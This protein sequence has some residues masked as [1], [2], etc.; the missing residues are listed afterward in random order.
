MRVM[1]IDAS[2][3][4]T[5]YAIF[6]G[7]Q[8]VEYGAIPVDDITKPWRE[9]IVYMM[10]SLSSLITEKNIIQIIIETPVKTL[11][12]VNTL[13]QLFSLHG[14]LIG[15][16]ASHH[17]KVVPVEVSEW[18]QELGLSKGIKK[19]DN[20]KAILKQ[21]SIELANQLYGLDLKWKSAGSKFND[22]DIS[23]AI[24]IGHAVLYKNE[25][26]I[27]NQIKVGE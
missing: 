20:K 7:K 11:Q 23:D 2:T 18:R 12:N 26:M 1:S 3:R 10:Q 9:R 5:G 6:V 4:K 27:G 24:L 19:G 15:M 8:L 14:A 13:E 22:D 21:R 17:C 25:K 16:G